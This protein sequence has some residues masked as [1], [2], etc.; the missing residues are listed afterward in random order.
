MDMLGNPSFRQVLTEYY[1]DS[2]EPKLVRRAIK[3]A[4]WKMY[5]VSRSS[6]DGIGAA[7][8]FAVFGA[9]RVCNQNNNLK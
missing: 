3:V 9:K 5:D 1:H 7:F 4:R 8:G 2:T 6:I